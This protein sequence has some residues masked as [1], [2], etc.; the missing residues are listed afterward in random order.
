[1]IN[2]LTKKML[3]IGLSVIS[4]VPITTFLSCS[5][6]KHAIENKL[7]DLELEKNVQLKINYSDALLSQINLLD[8]GSNTEQ[9]NE[10]GAPLEES[11]NNAQ[12]ANIFALPESKNAETN[13]NYGIFYSWDFTKK[14]IVSFDK[15]G[16]ILF[17]VNVNVGLKTSSV[18]VSRP[19]TFIINI[20]ETTIKEEG[21]NATPD[22]QPIMVAKPAYQYIYNGIDQNGNQMKYKF[23]AVRQDVFEKSKEFNIDFYSYNSIINNRPVIVEDKATNDSAVDA[24]TSKRLVKAP[25]PAS[26]NKTRYRFSIESADF[27]ELNPRK[28]I[29]K[30][31]VSPESDRNFDSNFLKYANE[32]YKISFNK[33]YYYYEKNKVFKSPT[34]SNISAHK[35]KNTSEANL[36]GNSITNSDLA[37]LPILKN[38]GSIIGKTSEEIVKINSETPSGLFLPPLFTRQYSIEP[39]KPVLINISSLSATTED[40]LTFSMVVQVG[41]APYQISKSFDKKVNIKQLL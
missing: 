7:L 29:Y 20:E 34:E 12:L 21:Q 4:I 37:F 2:R 38:P 26:I 36:I 30:V 24:F 18:F 15:S 10:K 5:N 35:S 8:L 17:E 13:E 27:D 6:E 9:L 3:L 14:N 33:F 19:R 40:Q 41:N 31:R 28:G 39:A 25:I 1:M 22:G 23:Q 11:N 32:K 16:N